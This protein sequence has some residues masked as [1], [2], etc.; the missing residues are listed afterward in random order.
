[1][2]LVCVKAADGIS[3]A[4][5]A[6]AATA[7]RRR[8][9]ISAI[10]FLFPSQILPLFEGQ[11]NISDGPGRRVM[12]SQSRSHLRQDEAHFPLAMELRTSLVIHGGFQPA[13]DDRCRPLVTA[14][15]LP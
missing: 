8:M 6:A 11:G 13:G 14:A 7:E 12:C 9:R 4:A 2:V 3:A 1:M 5:I 15:R 10:L